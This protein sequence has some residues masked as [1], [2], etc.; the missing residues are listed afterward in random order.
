MRRWKNGFRLDFRAGFCPW[1]SENV[2]V[3]SDPAFLPSDARG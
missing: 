3:E 2:E 1:P